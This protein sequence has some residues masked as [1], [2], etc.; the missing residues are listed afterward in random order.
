MD[1]LERITKQ[2]SELT[3]YDVTSALNKAKNIVLNLSE[4]EIKVRDCT[5]NDPWYVVPLVL[6]TSCCFPFF[7]VDKSECSLLNQTGVPARR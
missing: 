3:V 6:D 1:F 4:I 5:T 7:P 2:A